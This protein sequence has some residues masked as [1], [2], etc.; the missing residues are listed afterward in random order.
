MIHC[1]LLIP[2]VPH[3]EGDRTQFATYYGHHS[4]WQSDHIDGLGYYLIEHGHNWRA[5]PVFAENA[6]ERLRDEASKEIGVPY[7]LARYA[8][9]AF[10]LRAFCNLVPVGR[11][12]RPL[13]AAVARA[14][15]WGA[16][17]APRHHATTMV[18]Q[19]VC[20]PGTRRRVW[21]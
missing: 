7:S 21:R 17:A 11:A 3:D 14:Q 1:E 10:P 19:P 2:P 6:A 12:C 9:S 4:A 15:E 8:T 20:G 5:L 16:E 18:R 13:A